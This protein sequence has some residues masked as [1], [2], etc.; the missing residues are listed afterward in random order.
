MS[1]EEAQNREIVGEEDENGNATPRY[2]G[3]ILQKCL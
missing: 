3:K 1:F 2:E